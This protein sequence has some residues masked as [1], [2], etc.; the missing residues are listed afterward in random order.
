MSACNTQSC[1]G[2]SSTA[3]FSSTTTSSTAMEHQATSGDGSQTTRLPSASLEKAFSTCHHQPSSSIPNLRTGS[4]QASG[5][6]RTHQQENPTLGLDA[7][8]S[9]Q[10]PSGD[11]SNHG[12]TIDNW[13]TSSMVHHGHRVH[14]TTVHISSCQA[15]HQQQSRQRRKASQHRRRR[16]QQL[17]I[18]NRWKKRN[19]HQRSRRWQS[20]R[21]RQLIQLQHQHHFHHQWFQQEHQ[22]EVQHQGE[23]WTTALQKEVHRSNKRQQQNNRQRKDQKHQQ[24]HQ[25]T[26]DERTHQCDHS[27]NEEWTTSDNSNMWR[28]NRSKS[29]TTIDGSK[30]HKDLIR[31]N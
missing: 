19:H 20:Q 10:E 1:H 6:E 11:K 14:H 17:R 5:L 29:T 3:L 25:G 27:T 31:R 23:H 24:N 28:S 16:H 26:K 18:N 13:W 9:K 4:I 8:P 15:R 22:L 12:N 7:R 21:R 30:I 2:S